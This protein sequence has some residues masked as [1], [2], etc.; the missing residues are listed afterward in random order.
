MPLRER[1]RDAGLTVL[2]LLER[3]P[4]QPWSGVILPVP[5]LGAG[6]AVEEG[7]VEEG[8]VE[9]GGKEGEGE[10]EPVIVTPGASVSIR[11]VAWLWS[12]GVAGAGR[13]W[14]RPGRVAYASFAARIW[15]FLTRQSLA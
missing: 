15:L 13:S 3:T 10:G 6:G 4:V 7:A 1:A 5:L 14:N 11:S 2:A 9:E 8:A 12:V